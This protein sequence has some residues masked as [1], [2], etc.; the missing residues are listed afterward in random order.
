MTDRIEGPNPSGLCLCGCGQATRIAPQG[1]TERG[2]VKGQP[3]PYIR[4]H[5]QVPSRHYLS[6][7]NETERTATCTL[8]GPTGV[9]KNGAS[10]WRCL[11]GQASAVV[12]NH[13]L[14]EIDE[15]RRTALCSQCGLVSITITGSKRWLCATK[16]RADAKK[17]RERLAKAT[18][19]LTQER[20]RAAP[21]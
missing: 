1:S 3:I 6:E 13:S 9:K 21:A 14:T 18:T 20:S 17:Y 7:I 4:G 8:C 16:S 5:A 12:T 10:G 2:W 19:Y 11:R 15:S